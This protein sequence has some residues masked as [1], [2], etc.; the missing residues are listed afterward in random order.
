MKPLM[1]TLLMVFAVSAQAEWKK[2]TTYKLNALDQSR[3]VDVYIDYSTIRRS[4][5]TA[6]GWLLLDTVRESESRFVKPSDYRS[7]KGL[8]EFDCYDYKLRT[9]AEVRHAGRMGT[10]RVTWTD[11]EISEWRPVPPQSDEANMMKLFCK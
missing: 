10:G 9:H 6:R 3:D 7:G 4:G 2:V 1:C 11:Y 5:N 8:I